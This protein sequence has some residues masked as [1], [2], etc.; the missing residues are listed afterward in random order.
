[1]GEK[2]GAAPRIT[3]TRRKIRSRNFFI[4]ML[5]LLPGIRLLDNGNEVFKI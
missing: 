3:G 5:L 4:F 1:V 2:S